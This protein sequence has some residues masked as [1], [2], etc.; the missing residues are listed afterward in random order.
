[1]D[2]V[3]ILTVLRLGDKMA[4][5]LSVVTS[6]SVVPLLRVVVETRPSSTAETAEIAEKPEKFS[7]NLALFAVNLLATLQGRTTRFLNA[8]ILIGYGVFF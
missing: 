7:A 1:M 8:S 5:V 2:T 4:C 3:K 6:F